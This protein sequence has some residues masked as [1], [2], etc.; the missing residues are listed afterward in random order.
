MSDVPAARDLGVR[1]LLR[2][3]DFR[4]LYLAQAISDLGD[5]MTYL[6]L[7]LIILALT[8]STAVIAVASILV[9]VPPVTVGLVAGAIADRTDRRRLMIGSDALRA[10]VM[11]AMVPVAIAG[12]VPVL[13]ALAFVQ[14]VIGTFFSPARAAVV[15]RAVPAEGMLAASSLGQSTRMI[16]GVVGAGI[17]GVVASVAGV[18]WPVLLVDAATFAVSALIVLGV[19]PALGI[20][21]A[22]AGADPAAAASGQ[23]RDGL[24]AAVREGLG[25]VARS[26]VLVATLTGIAVTMLGVGAINVLFVPFIVRDLGASP[27]WTGLFDGAQVLSMVLAGGLVTTVAARLST[28]RLFT[29]CLL[30]AGG[31]TALM[32]VAPNPPAV[33][34]VLFLVGWF[35]MPIQVTTSTIIALATDDA[36]RGRVA[37]A[38]NA[39]IQTATIASMALA[40]ILADVISIRGVFAAGSVLVVLAAVISGL[41]FRGA[42][43]PGDRASVRGVRD[44][45]RDD[46]DRGA[47][48]HV[49]ERAVVRGRLEGDAPGLRSGSPSSARPGG[50]R[51]DQPRGA[52][53]KEHEALA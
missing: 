14:A 16:M 35:V 29:I 3:P 44:D 48:D 51:I 17:T 18:A 26:R 31:S 53:R 52:D 2:L 15:P 45:G 9:A 1:D 19:T 28:S 37:G 21:E 11:V 33:L 12:A 38:L 49:I 4:R 8:G 30:G 25:I 5:G 7:F 42:R 24:G 6:A 39:V 34:A 46:L 32:A 40:G 47:D 10:A 23:R 50:D 22:L 13:L 27:A 43:V 20:P 41:L 36:S